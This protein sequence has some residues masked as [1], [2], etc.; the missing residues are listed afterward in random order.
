MIVFWHISADFV[1][2]QHDWGLL[3]RN[4]SSR[5]VLSDC[6]F[7][8]EPVVPGWYDHSFVPPSI[9]AS[10]PE[11]CWCTGS[12]STG[13]ASSCAACATGTPLFSGLNCGCHR[14]RAQVAGRMRHGRLHLHD[15]QA[16]VSCLR[17]AFARHLVSRR[18]NCLLDALR[19]SNL[20]RRIFLCWHCMHPVSCRYVCNHYLCPRFTH[21]SG[22][23]SNDVPQ[24]SMRLWGN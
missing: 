5:L 3:R 22:V 10:F 13:N 8:C 16:H 18:C 19:R 2:A 15:I 4:L 9:H 23:H 20:C 11:T 17:C 7:D 6:W 12:Y 14:D 21:T 1:P 24:A